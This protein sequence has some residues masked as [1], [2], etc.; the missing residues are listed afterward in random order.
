MP[1]TLRLSGSLSKR[2]N[3]LR[4]V[5]LVVGLLAIVLGMSGS[6]LAVGRAPPLEDPDFPQTTS[7]AG[8]TVFYTTTLSI[9]T[10]PYA[11]ISRTRLQCR[12]QYDLSGPGL[13]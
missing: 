4:W 5:S 1:H 2:R 8:T 10:Y 12:L 13:G 9:P 3:H 7:L 11:A 6:R